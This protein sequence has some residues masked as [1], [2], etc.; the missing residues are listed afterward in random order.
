MQASE[1]QVM[2]LVPVLTPITACAFIFTQYSVSHAFV[3]V[4]QASEEQVTKLKADLEK[5]K[6]ELEAAA[7]AKLEEA[8]AAFTKQLAEMQTLLAD[9][10]TQV[11]CMISQVIHNSA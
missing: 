6:A 11:R 8:E 5:Q 10:Q 9:Y 1:E 4:V 7:T 2:K 3:A